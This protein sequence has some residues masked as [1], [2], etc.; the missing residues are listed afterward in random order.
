[1]LFHLLGPV[2]IHDAGTVSR[3][4]SGKAAVVLAT[5]LLHR[6]V[7]VAVD[8]LVD[9]V[10]P[11]HAAPPSAEANI[12]TYVSQLRRVVPAHPDGPRIERRPGAYRLRVTTGELDTDRVDSLAASAAR[13][14]AEGDPGTAVDLLRAALRLWRGR[15]F[16]GLHGSGFDVV[17]TT[18][19]EQRITLTERLT[20]LLVRVGRGAEA[21]VTLRALTVDAPL[22]EQT[23]SRLVL[24]LHATGHRGE[25]IATYRRA[26]RLLTTELG[27][28]PGPALT[29]AHRLIR[30]AA[31]V[32]DELPRDVPVAGRDDVLARVCRIATGTAPVV[33]VDGLVGV[34]KTAFAVHAAHRLAPGYPDGRFFVALGTGAVGPGS[35]LRRLLRAIGVPPA[36]TPSD[37]EAMAALWRVHLRRR[38]V[39]V[40]LDDAVDGAQVAPLLPGAP[41]SLTLVTTGRRDWHPDGAARVS[42]RPLGDADATALVRSAAGGRCTASAVASVVGRCGGLPAA[43]RDVTARLLVRPHWTV[44]RLVDEFDDDPGR[45]LSDSVRRSVDT[46]TRGLDGPA[47][48]AWHALADLPPDF[49]PQTAARILGLPLFATRTALDTLV[50]RG[51]LEATP[52]DGYRSHVVLRQLTMYGTRERATRHAAQRSGAIA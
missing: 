7:W 29:E 4:G 6:N 3:P 48:S 24:A 49:A 11:E 10:W 33:V 26:H 23:W 41:G 35:V 12:K 5:L 45:V 2:E 13:A 19:E 14:T 34:G 30:A 31:P 32:H 44:Q 36:E 8:R 9:V 21:V 25:A 51:L 39:L 43:L 1:M 46:A 18:F 50:E 47:L 28:E 40:V 15:A 52:A 27:L 16:E 20:D 17:S 38:R 42:L 22:R 37:V